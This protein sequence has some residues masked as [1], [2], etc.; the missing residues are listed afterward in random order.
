MTT[1]LQDPRI[2]AGMRAQQA[3]LRQR[4]DAGARQIG[5]K[6]GFGAPAAKEKLRIGAPLVGFLL[7]TALLPPGSGVSLRGWQKPVAEP[8]IAVHMR[9]DLP[10]GADVETVR[11]AIAGLGPAIE[12]ADI[13][14]PMDDV[15]A[16]LSGD[17]FQRHVL[18]GP[19]DDS[20]RGARLAGLTARVRRGGQDVPVPADLE[21]NIGPIVETVRHVADMAAAIGEALRGGHFVI[22]GSLTPPLFLE[23]SDSAIDFALDPVG[24]IGV[25]FTQ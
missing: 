3:L 15:Q 10:A 17:I 6:V 23:A 19:R 14:C 16:I 24:T 25:R 4:L 11:S 12:L 8:E 18:L 2:A 21:A 13:D 20:R 9:A 5:W 1:P 22:C 7:D